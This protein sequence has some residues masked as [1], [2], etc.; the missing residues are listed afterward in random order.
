VAAEIVHAEEIV[1]GADVPE[2][3]VVVAAEAGAVVRA[4]AGADAAGVLAAD[5]VGRGTKASV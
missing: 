3:V 2:A 1:A 5:T 4:A